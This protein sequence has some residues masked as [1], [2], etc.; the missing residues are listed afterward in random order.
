MRPIRVLVAD[1]EPHVREILAAVIGTDDRLHLVGQ[2]EE[3]ESAIGMAAAERPDVALVDVRMPGGGGARAARG[4]VQRSATT[5]VVALSAFDDAETILSMLRAG[6]SA[7]VVK[8]DPT[9]DILAAIHRAV[10]EERPPGNELERIVS[11][12]DDWKARR[13]QRDDADVDRRARVASSALSDGVNLRFEPVVH[14]ISGEVVGEEAIA[15]ARGTDSPTQWVAEL[16]RAGELVPFETNLVAAA[17]RELDQLLSSRWVSVGISTDSVE[18]RGLLRALREAPPNRV[19]L[20]LSELDRTSDR[21]GLARAISSLRAG[22]AR[23]ALDHV[24]PGID[25][26]RDLVAIRPTFAKLDP[27]LLEDIERDRVR[28]RLV[29]A[30]VRVA[31]ELDCEVVARGVD[32]IEV[33][34]TLIDLGIELG[35]GRVLSTADPA[36]PGGAASTG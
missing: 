29:H 5:R 6:A 7:Y 10:S 13:T 16:R 12:F 34:E 27:T 26:I 33:V 31:D 8:T 1:D 23:I 22:G 32:R 28:A 3:A 17:I 11:A 2:A 15:I 4:I 24:G 14:L 35:Q 18:N 36:L 21:D 20:Q 9:G 19:V 30:I 25:S